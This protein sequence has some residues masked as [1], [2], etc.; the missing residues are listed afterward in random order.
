[1]NLIPTFWD[2]NVS[3]KYIVPL[4]LYKI[5]TNYLQRNNSVS[6]KYIVP[7]EFYRKYLKKQN[8]NLKLFG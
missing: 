4:E 3:T 5:M 2:L 7:S 6:T 8:V 1:M